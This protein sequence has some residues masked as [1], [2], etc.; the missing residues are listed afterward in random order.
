MKSFVTPIITG[1]TGISVNNTWKSFN[2][3][4]KNSCTREIA[5]NKESATM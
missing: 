2:R 1:A 3:P 5:R 4:Y